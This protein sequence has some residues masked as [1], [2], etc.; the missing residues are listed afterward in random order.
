MSIYDEFMNTG[1]WGPI[2]TKLGIEFNFCCAYCDKRMLES[3]ENYKEWQTDHII[4]SSK[5]GKDSIENYALSCR[6]CNFIKSTWNPAENLGEL[7]ITKLNLINVSKDYII[8]K[9]KGTL[10]EIA[11]YNQIIAKYS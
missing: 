10:A 11:L 8:E 1:H 9:R 5:D 3:V 2:E 7:N 6:T 4:P